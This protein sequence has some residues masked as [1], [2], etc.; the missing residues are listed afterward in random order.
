M[1]LH[2]NCLFL[3]NVHAEL[4]QTVYINHGLTARRAHCLYSEDHAANL[5]H[6]RLV[7]EVIQLGDIEIMLCF[8]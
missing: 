7:R 8:G 6:E 3:N 1:T 5:E 4:T 2:V